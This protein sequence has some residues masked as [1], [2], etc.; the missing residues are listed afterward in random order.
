M[1][2]FLTLLKLDARLAARHKL[3]HVTVVIAALFGLLTALVLPA[4][5][6]LPILFAVDLC[7]L[8]FMF[9]AVT[10][11][12]DKEHGTIRF[13]RGGPGAGVAYVASTRTVNLG[14]SLISLPSLVG[15]GEPRALAEPSLIALVLLACAGMTLLG[16]GLAVFF[17]G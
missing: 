16:M 3:I 7:V 9:G 6:F 15:L 17:R 1:T 12:Q 8:G 14:R 2:G 4:D 11:L 5:P 13:Y 10:L